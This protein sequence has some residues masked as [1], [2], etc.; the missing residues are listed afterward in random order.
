MWGA[1]ALKLDFLLAILSLLE[2]PSFTLQNFYH[3]THGTLHISSLGFTRCHRQP[4]Y[5]ETYVILSADNGEE[6][7]LSGMRR[8]L[9]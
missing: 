1:K 2:N 7:P 5:L 9:L 3:V 4:P 8:K 6:L